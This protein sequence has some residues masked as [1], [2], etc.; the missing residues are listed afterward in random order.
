[1]F[2]KRDKKEKKPKPPVLSTHQIAKNKKPDG[3]QKLIEMHPNSFYLND[4]EKTYIW[5]RI[6]EDRPEEMASTLDLSKSGLKAIIKKLAQ[7]SW[8]VKN[9]WSG[10]RSS[11]N[12][13]RLN[14][15][16][17]LVDYSLGLRYATDW[18]MK[19]SIERGVAYYDNEGN[20]KFKELEESSENDS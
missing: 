15:V 18:M 17:S 3:V 14:E 20:F 8:F 13:Y 9:G 7:T 1:M 11:I 6:L 4:E 12:H 2:W 16:Q 5:C 10:D 19:Q